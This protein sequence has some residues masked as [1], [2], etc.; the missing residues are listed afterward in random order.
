MVLQ[1]GAG[2]GTH[3]SLQAEAQADAEEAEQVDQR[4]QGRR[5]R[6]PDAA[7]QA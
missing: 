5:Q 3:R 4:R 7:K 2:H 6:H 1:I